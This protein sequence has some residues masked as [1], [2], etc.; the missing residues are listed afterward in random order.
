MVSRDW[1]EEGWRFALM[2]TDSVW[3][4]YKVLEMM[5]VMAAQQ[6]NVL[7]ATQPWTW[8]Y[9]LQS[10]IIVSSFWSLR[11]ETKGKR[12]AQRDSHWET[13]GKKSSKVNSPGRWVFLDKHISC[14]FC[15]QRAAAF[16]SIISNYCFPLWFF[17]GLLIPREFTHIS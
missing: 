3:K 17:C 8:W 11:E 7:N 6:Y 12:K 1:G 9:I 10:C 15:V 16:E 5:G 14:S 4:D 13:R 2:R